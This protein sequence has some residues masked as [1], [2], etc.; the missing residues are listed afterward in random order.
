MPLIAVA[1]AAVADFAAAGAIGAVI[2]GSTAIA[3]IAATVAAVGATV[4]AV[5]SVTHDKTPQTAG[6]VLGAVGGVDFLA[7][8][9][10]RLGD[11]ATVG[12]VFGT[13]GADAASTGTDAFSDVAQNADMGDAAATAADTAAG[14]GGDALDQAEGLFNGLPGGTSDTANAAAA[15]VPAGTAPPAGAAASAATPAGTAPAATDGSILNPVAVTAMNPSAAALAGNVTG[16]TTLGNI[17]SFLETKGGGMVGMGVV[18]AAGSFLAG[19]TDT[20]KPAQVAQYQAQANANNAA[21]ALTNKQVANM[22]QPVPT[23]TRTA[24]TGAP[25]A[26]PMMQPAVLGGMINQPT[27]GPTNVNQLPGTTAT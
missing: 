6:M 8:A 10:R 2:A 26:T 4:S 15:D 23:A 14:S 7:N 25:A 12:S 11:A 5:G 3:D 9:G 18:Q 1:V 16:N 17:Q 21:A 22:A 20:L 13:S 27:P 24:V 19:A